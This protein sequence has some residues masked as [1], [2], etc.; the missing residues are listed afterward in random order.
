MF[1]SRWGRKQNCCSCP[2]PFFLPFLY[3]SIFLSALF[4]YLFFF[5]FFSY[6]SLFLIFPYS[7]YFPF[8]P[9][10][11]L[12]FLFFLFLFSFFFLLSL[13]F[14]LFFSPFF[15]LFPFSSFFLLFSFSFSS[16]L[17]SFFSFFSFFPSSPFFSFFILFL[18]VLISTSFWLT[19]FLRRSSEGDS[20]GWMEGKLRWVPAA[21][22]PHPTRSTRFFLRFAIQPGVILAKGKNKQ[23][24]QVRVCV[25]RG[26]MNLPLPAL[27]RFSQ[28]QCWGRAKLTS[29]Q[30]SVINYLTPTRR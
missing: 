1:A 8:S 14:F 25:I 12:F 5:F 24:P 2:S 7:S 13:F 30:S 19:L 23:L 20:E 10:L 21:L 15:R 3:L 17:I 26:L 9:F 4:S 22:S 27:P 29:L 6:F 16:F 11:P 28:L 18:V